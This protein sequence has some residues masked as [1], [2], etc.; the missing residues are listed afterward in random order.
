MFGERA[1]GYEENVPLPELGWPIGL[2]AA[3]ITKK[4]NESEDTVQIGGKIELKLNI[5]RIFA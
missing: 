4:T 2:E 1:Q 3:V 5:S